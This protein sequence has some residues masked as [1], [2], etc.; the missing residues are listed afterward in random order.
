MTTETEETTPAGTDEQ[1][2]EKPKLQMEIKVDKPSACERHVT[3]S[4]ARDDVERYLKEAFDELVPKA[5]VPGFRAGR[6]PR[7]L[8]QS[9]FKEQ[10][11][12]QVTGK[13]LMDSLSQ[14]GDDQEFS[15]ISEPDFDF[16]TIQMPDDGPMHFEFDIEVRPE[17]DLPE[18]K[19]MQL[20][21]PVE[22]Y[23]EEKVREHLAK[24]LA[25]YATIEDFDGPIGPGHFATV[26]L[27]ATHNGEQIS[28]LTEET[29]EVKPVLSFAD[30]KLAGFDQL[31]LGKQAGDKVETT[32]T[33]SAEAENEA[34]RDQEI[35]LSIEVVAVEQRKLP[36]LTP[37]FLEKIGGFASEDELLAE[38]RKELERQL[39]FHQQRRVRQ[40]ITGLLTVAANWELPKDMLRR[41]ASREYDRM[42][43]E[44]QSSGFTDSMIQSYMNE[45]RQNVL[46]STARSLKE[47]FIL[48][49][50]A[51]EQKVEALPE[52][53]D[54]EVEL[55]ADQS[56]ESPRRVRARLEKR[57][58][59][60]TLRNQIIERKVIEL[61]ESQAKYQD[62][63]HKPTVDETVAVNYSLAGAG[64]TDVPEA[65]FNEA[66]AQPGS[67]KL[68]DAK[69]SGR[70]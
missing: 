60:D 16:D 54:R 36:E 33:I 43:M 69:E 22:D 66:V 45:I 10:I 62:V 8:V 46:A 49:R 38:V 64:T 58:L 19:G 1:Q 48:E 25:R 9:R 14:M 63:P 26:T 21:R 51:E 5:E 15:A 67:P 29:I 44:L 13:L 68:P 24:L 57:G 27:R 55:I 12:D 18:W 59:M 23:S 28:Q 52:D 17:F 56:D 34:L 2:A 42:V 37:A 53:Y 70:S 4:I 11:V 20:E 65:K 6:A 3:V 61:I 32:V 7:K 35:A 50:I 47:H 39:K 30:A 40:Q 41:Q 31:L